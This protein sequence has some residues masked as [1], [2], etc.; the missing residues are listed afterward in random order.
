MLPS[1][2]EMRKMRK[3][4]GISQKEL[5]AA[6]GVSQS[7]IARLEKGSINPTY[8][9]VR[10]IYDFLNRKGMTS[11]S[12]EIMAEKIMSRNVVSC[13]P[14]DSISHALDL[15]RN[16]GYSQL[17]VLGS[18]GR[19]VGTITES[20]INDLLVRGSSPESLKNMTVRKVMGPVLPQIDRSASVSMLYQL[21][22]FYS[23]VLVL[24]EGKLKGIITKSDVLKA[25]GTYG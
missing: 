11:Q 16:G 13:T 7:Y 4:L 17:P 24:E 20:D 2:Q 3:N 5:A 9:K 19:I 18:D 12:L 15:M 10:N 21:L 1:I 25:V 8:E 6:T 22:K 23:A 14:S